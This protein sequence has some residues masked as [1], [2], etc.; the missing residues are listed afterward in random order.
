MLL[1]DFSL[2]SFQIE[3]N[4]SL[5]RIPHGRPYNSMYCSGCSRRGHLV[6]T[7]R[8][9][10]PFSGL[11]INSPYVYVYRPVYG[12]ITQTKNVSYTNPTVPSRN[13]SHKRQSKSPTNHATHLNKKRSMSESD[14]RFSKSSINTP[15]NPPQ[16]DKTLKTPNKPAQVQN[17][18]AMAKTPEYI[19]VSSSNHDDNGHM[20]QDNEVSDTSDVVTSARIYV[21]N[22]LVEKLKTKEGAEWLAA[23]SNKLQ[24]TVENADITSFLTIKGKVADQE[25]F[26]IELREWNQ[27]NSESEEPKPEKGVQLSP[28]MPKNRMQLLQFIDN[29]LNSLNE[30]LGDPKAIYKELTFS[31]NR[32]QKL[33]K[34]RVI[35]PR[36]LSHSRYHINEVLKKLNMLL[37]GQAGLADGPKHIR[38]LFSLKEKVA[39]F[40]RKTIP[41]NIR[42]E[43]DDHYKNIFGSIERKDYVDLLNKYYVRKPP[44]I[45]KKKIKII[46]TKYVYK[47][48]IPSTENI[49]KLQEDNLNKPIQNVQNNGFKQQNNPKSKPINVTHN[50]IR[51]NSIQIDKLKSFH[52]QLLKAQPCEVSHKKARIELI[53]RLHTL[54]ASLLGKD[55]IPSKMRKKVR[56]TQQDAL[57]LL[58]NM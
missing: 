4:M 40:L 12:P 47:N 31:Q 23:T 10:I 45:P 33:L 25:T 17:V 27:R 16:E 49:N 39:N 42:Q 41:M 35:N 34:K 38:K 57:N 54:I 13:D 52:K 32:H 56:K 5:E 29:A 46:N 44:H 58:T 24:I 2:V 28:N 1:P 9:T 36:V 22:D 43:I 55:N 50:E 19:P 20:I 11:P 37:L 21:T 14:T 3:L 18:S 7:C 48:S 6:H 8:S 51:Q 30:E 53:R 26:Q 15:K